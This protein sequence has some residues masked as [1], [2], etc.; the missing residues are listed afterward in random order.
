M[1]NKFD[2]TTKDGFSKATQFF[3]KYGWAIVP[4]PWLLK[5]TFSPEISTEKQVEAAEKL[6]KAGKNEGVKEMH[7]KVS[8]DAGVKLGTNVEGVPLKIKIGNNGSMDVKV[9]YK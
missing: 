7:L 6:I 4:I 3:D 2:L 1:D 5:K 8:H 9:V